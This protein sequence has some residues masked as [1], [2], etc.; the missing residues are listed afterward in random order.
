MATSAAESRSQTESLFAEN[1]EPFFNTIGQTLPIHS[2]PA[3]TNVRSCSNSGH[4][5]RQADCPLSANRVILY[6][7]KN[8]IR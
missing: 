1:N 4:S 5:L 8:V 6:R 2:M 3:P 7:S